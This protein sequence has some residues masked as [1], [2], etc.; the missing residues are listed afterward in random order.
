VIGE[1]PEAEDLYTHK[2]NKQKNIDMQSKDS[3][4]GIIDVGN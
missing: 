3:I 1:L 2:K 4:K